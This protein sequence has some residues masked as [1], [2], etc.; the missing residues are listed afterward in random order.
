[1]KYLFLLICIGIINCEVSN[2]QKTEEDLNN[3]KFQTN[4]ERELFFYGGYHPFF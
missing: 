3:E 2:K 4:P 1:M